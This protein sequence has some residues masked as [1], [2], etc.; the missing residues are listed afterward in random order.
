MHWVKVR[1]AWCAQ[2][3]YRWTRRWLW[4]GIPMHNYIS[5]MS[6]SFFFFIYFYGFFF[7]HHSKPVLLLNR[8]T[9]WNNIFV[10]MLTMTM[11]FRTINIIK[12]NK[13]IMK[14]TNEIKTICT[15]RNSLFSIFILLC[16]F[17]IDSFV[18]LVFIYFVEMTILAEGAC[19]SSS[20]STSNANAVVSH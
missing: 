12:Q 3:Y 8:N 6:L 16:V 7:F 19:L 2:A 18:F 20:T 11:E 1:F 14:H 13:Y 17:N 4:Q 9:V 5:W 10:N 15:N